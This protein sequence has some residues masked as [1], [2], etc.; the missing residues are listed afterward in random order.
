MRLL[1]KTLVEPSIEPRTLL[2][3]SRTSRPY[4]KRCREKS[5]HGCPEFSAETN[6]AV[7]ET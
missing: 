7:T 6:S 4:N 1:D 2:R 5:G 3:I